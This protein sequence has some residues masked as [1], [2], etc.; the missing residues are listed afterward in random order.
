MGKFIT[1][2]NE[3]IADLH[4]MISVVDAHQ[5]TL[6]PAFEKKQNIYDRDG[7]GDSDI[8]RLLEGKI[9]API[10][11]LN[12]IK[13]T[14]N[15]RPK[16]YSQLKSALKLIS[17]IYQQLSI[18]KKAK[19]AKNVNDI[20][21]NKKSGLISIILSIEGG[22]ALEGDLDLLY[23][24]YQLGVRCIGLTHTE[25]NEIADSTN[26]NR[27]GGGL[28]NF[29]VDLIKKMNMMGVVIDL[30]HISQAGFYE[31]LSI[32]KKPV[33]VSH[34][35]VHSL[36]KNDRNLTDKQIKYL[37][38]NGGV[39]GITFCPFFLKENSQATLDDVLNHIDYV[40]DLVGINHVGIGSDYDGLPQ[41]VIPAKKL[42]Q[43]SKFTNLTKGLISRGYSDDQILKIVGG[44]FLRV[45]EQVW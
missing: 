16:V 7:D 8:K 6:I 14:K 23:I 9:W 24:F 40:I 5:D 1:D 33:I 35:N 4:N 39:L 12:V 44:N 27:T 25:R 18:I 34:A 17:Y 22:E 41:G 13:D 21:E 26:E 11:A 2:Q 19:I 10:Y 37:A 3:H 36:C 15:S 28:T 30:A 32:S 31:V 20:I 45:F 29:G 43:S 38:K 42:E